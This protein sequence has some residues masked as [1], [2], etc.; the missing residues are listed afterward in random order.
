MHFEEQAHLIL[1]HPE[2]YEALGSWN[3]HDVVFRIWRYPALQHPSSWALGLR[4]TGHRVRRLE[5]DKA[6][7]VYWPLGDP[8]IY[9]SEAEVPPENAA[10]I[11]DELGQLAFP[12]FVM[13][14]SIGIDGIVY[15]VE[16]CSFYLS[17]RA[18]WWC[19]PPPLW[20]PVAEWFER[21]VAVFEA[22][23]PPSTAQLHSR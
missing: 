13:R 3:A 4:S 16:T 1:A 17:A 2:R 15:G 20:A 18:S 23:L 5:W 6:K 9:G 11:I 10:Q 22:L 8:T 7:D 21:T 12:P 19:E 14:N